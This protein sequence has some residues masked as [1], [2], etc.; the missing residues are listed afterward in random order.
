MLPHNVVKA[1]GTRNCHV[2]EMSEAISHER[3]KLSYKIQPL[4]IVDEKVLSGD[5]SII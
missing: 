3:L 1:F 2:H 4:K 5:V